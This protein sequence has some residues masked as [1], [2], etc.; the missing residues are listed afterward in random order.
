MYA[1]REAAVRRL[2]AHLHRRYYGYLLSIAYRHAINQ[3]DAEEALQEALASFVR[4]FDP[5]SGAP[6]LAW[7]TLTLKRE[8]WR[9][10]RREQLELRAGQE[11]ERGSE[12]AGVVM[13]LIPSRGASLEERATGSLDAQRR[14]G[15][16]KPDQRTALCLLGAGFSYKEIAA[17]KGWTYS[18]V[19]R[20][21]REGRAALRE[22][23]AA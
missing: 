21:V 16:L 9:K 11:T 4:A 12:E 3:W 15:A 14:L 17:R 8:C 6:P 20:C 23:A 19:N 5:D 22:L 18:K 10:R 1:G 13:E 2:A 7:L